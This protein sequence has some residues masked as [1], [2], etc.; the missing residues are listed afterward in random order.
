MSIQSRKL[1]TNRHNSY[2]VNINSR[3]QHDITTPRTARDRLLR[4][5]SYTT[6]VGFTV[7]QLSAAAQSPVGR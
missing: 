7:V 6:K 2:S 4:Y 1:D 5:Q 3:Q